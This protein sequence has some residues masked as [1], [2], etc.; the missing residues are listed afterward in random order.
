[1]KNFIALLVILVGIQIHS[2]AQV[3]GN[4]L[5]NNSSSISSDKAAVNVNS[6]NGSVVMLKAEVM[7]NVK[8]TSY[9]AIFAMNQSGKDAFDVDSLLS[10]R[11]EFVKFHL[12]R[13]GIPEKDIHVDAVSVLPTYEYRIDRKKFSTRSTEIP[14]GFEMKKNIHILFKDIAALDGI[15]SSMA[16]ADIYDMV[17]VEYNIDGAQSYYDE[18]RDAALAVIETKKGT[19]GKLNLHL[20]PYNIA[21]GYSCTYP[22]ERY[23]SYTAFHSGASPYQVSIVT[24]DLSNDFN[25][26]KE[27][28]KAKLDKLN[29]EF[30]VQ[31]AEKNKTIFYD[32]MP[33]NQFDK[34]IN[35]DVAEPTIQYFYTLQVTFTMM[36]DEQYEIK[37]KNAELAK[38]QVGQMVEPK[39]KK[40]RKH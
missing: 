27:E 7:M 4:Y 2:L 15:I 14:T 28:R 16:L 33:Y 23:K 12:A 6:S 21:D 26:T 31:S 3:A 19:Y 29:H 36:T 5:Y 40:R 30:T 35:P 17:K 18:L 8:A 37:M 24:A 34:V 22:M 1:M 38:Q 32:R 39:Q 10:T 25:Y 13:I 20:D 9:T 11:I